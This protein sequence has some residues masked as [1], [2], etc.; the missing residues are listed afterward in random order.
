M[1]EDDSDAMSKKGPISPSERLYSSRIIS[2]YIKFIRTEY[3]RVDINDILSYAG[4]ESYQVEDDAYWF[5]QEQ[6]DRYS[7]TDFTREEKAMGLPVR[8]NSK[9]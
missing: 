8:S 4:M 3:S 2:S 9:S 7:K 5:T 1:G 6:V